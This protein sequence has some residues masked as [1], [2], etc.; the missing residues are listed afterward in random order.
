MISKAAGKVNKTKLAATIIASFAVFA[1]SFFAMAENKNLNPIFLD[2]DQDGLTD[3]EENSL[4]TDSQKMDTDGDG[5]SDGAEIKSGYNPLK[6]APGDQ[7][8]PETANAVQSKLS[9]TEDKTALSTNDETP[10]ENANLS[11][12]LKQSGDATMNQSTSL[13]GNDSLSSD[14]VNDLSSDPENPNLTNEMIGQLLQTTLEKA[15]TT[16]DFEENPSFSQDDFS[17]ITQKSLETA[18][19]AKDLPEI[20]PEE[21]KILPPVDDED[22]SKEEIKDKQKKEIEK[23]LSSLAF[24]FASN[25]PFSIDNTVNVATKLNAESDSLISALAAGDSEKIDAYAQKARAGIDQV[26]KVEVP[27]VL[28]DIHKSIL[29]LSIYTL[30]FKEDLVVSPT[31]PLRGLAAF[32][33]LQSV[34]ESALKIQADLKSVLDE[35]GISSVE[36]SP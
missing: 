1:I 18:S 12:L 31:D 24:I 26:K 33:A 11:E 29:Q 17:S 15:G 34:G 2:S 35:Y 22:L 36:F 9:N 4:G 30:D 13:L 7:L 32:G 10:K 28:K 3:Q 20:K 8:F 6:S 23:Y 5:Y 21:M 14:V 16:E 19:V 27:Y 25:A